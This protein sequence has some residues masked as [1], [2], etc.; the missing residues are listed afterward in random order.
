MLGERLTKETGYERH[1][2]EW[3]DYL[4][5]AFEREPVGHR[6]LRTLVLRLKFELG[7]AVASVPF[8]LASF[9]IPAHCPR[10]IGLAL[11]GVG[12]RICHH[13]LCLRIQKA[14]HIVLGI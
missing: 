1:A 3:F 2:K 10:R 9:F 6:Y 11:A 4:R 5:L 13:G 7:M 8:T 14:L 12:C